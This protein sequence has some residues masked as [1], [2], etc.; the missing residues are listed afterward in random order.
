MPGV[1]SGRACDG[2]RKQKK[3][4]DEK[5]P[6]CSRCIRLKIKCVGS[7]QQR[8][9]FQQ[10]KG[11]TPILYTTHTKVS[12][13]ESDFPEAISNASEFDFIVTLPTNPKQIHIGL[14][15]G[16]SPAVALSSDLSSLAIRFI[17][18]IARSTDLRYNLWWSFG[19][20]LEDI[21]R[22]LGANEALD[23]SIE[24]L[25]AAHT[26]FC[27]VDR[28]G[29]TVE[30]LTKYSQAL[31]TLRVY[32]DDR[33][34]AQSS[35]TLCAVMVLLVCQLFLGQGTQCWSGHAEGAARILK[36]RRQ[37]T[38]RDLFEKKLFLSLRGSVLMEGLFNERINLTQKEWDELVTNEFDQN[39]PEGR[40]LQC[41]AHGPDLGRR[42]RHVLQVGMDPTYTRAEICTLYQTCKENLHELKSRAINND[43]S[44][45]DMTNVPKATE[46]HVREFF[47]AHYQRTYGIGLVV[48]LF[49]NCMLGALVA[50][51]LGDESGQI[52]S[53]DGT[54]LAA[55]VLALADRSVI[56]RPIGA[57]YLLI[58]LTAAWAAT[59]EPVLKAKIM[60]ALNDFNGDFKVKDPGHF[61][62]E[63]EWTAERL[64]LGVP[65]RIN[66]EGH[67]SIQS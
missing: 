45:I 57:G 23:R 31:R 19:A 62:Q 41:L 13:Q 10:E 49:F 53:A 54:K 18:T 43:I 3:K 65:F 14:P 56:Y 9:K 55:E 64:R 51:D 48:T 26:G 28:H 60:T 44:A 33:V 16:S 34:H 21:P 42:A 67:Y 35:N 4:C 25:T 40:I 46:K 52:V 50:D 30:A 32:L 15:P 27:G 24:A 59:R 11:Y 36:A 29:A 47:Y 39:T 12:K 2:C 37:C 17:K 38:P 6:S 8:F 61:R 22:R 66:G 58:C 1:P 7:G 5:Q 20:F 63:L